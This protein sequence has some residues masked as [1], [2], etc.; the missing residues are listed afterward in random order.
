MHCG[1]GVTGMN[2]SQA[3]NFWGVDLNVDCEVL[4]IGDFWAFVFGTVGS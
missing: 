4:P 2:W 3:T 1:G